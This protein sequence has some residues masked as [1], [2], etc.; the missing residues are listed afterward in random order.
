MGVV[1]FG[2]DQS[3]AGVDLVAVAAAA[4]AD[5]V[6]ADDSWTVVLAF[7]EAVVVLAQV[8]GEVLVVVQ[9]ME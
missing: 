4:A 7:L 9:K 6:G 1:E 5:V 2:R 8:E 3:W